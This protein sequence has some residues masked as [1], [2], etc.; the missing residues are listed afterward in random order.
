MSFTIWSSY[1]HIL[2][3]PFS[4]IFL[5]GW[6]C[7][8]IFDSFSSLVSLGAFCKMTV[9]D[10]PPISQLLAMMQL[11]IN[12]M[13]WQKSDYIASISSFLWWTTESALA[14][15]AMWGPILMRR[16]F[17]P[18]RPPCLWTRKS[19]SQHSHEKKI[20]RTRG[21]NGLQWTFPKPTVFNPKQL[22]YVIIIP[23]KTQSQ[24]PLSIP[25]GQTARTQSF[26]LE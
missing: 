10:Q 18:R 12:K 25:V 5:Y 24:P 20:S 19:P 6:C 13:V 16:A 22:K 7:Q 23:L 8:G 3:S 9:M 21:V 15:L 11:A 26:C 4:L 2:L 17:S 1:H 14:S